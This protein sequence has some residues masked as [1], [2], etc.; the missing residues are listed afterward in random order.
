MNRE[1]TMNL[2]HSLFIGL[3]L[4]CLFAACGNDNAATSNPQVTATAPPTSYPSISIDRLEYLWNNADYMDVVFYELPI[5][6]NQSTQEQVRSTIAH[7][8]EKTPVINPACKSVGRL[9]FQVKGK[10]VE[11]AEIYFENGCTYYVWLEN[12]KPAYANTITQAGIDF[13]NN[14]YVQAQQLNQ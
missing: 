6:L 2:L 1:P 8:S 9:F 11:E 7:I 13:Y 4:L 12:G 14:V 5:S 3:T 10:N